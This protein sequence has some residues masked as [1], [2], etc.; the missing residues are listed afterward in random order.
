MSRLFERRGGCA[1]HR[2][3]AKSGA[4]I[5]LQHKLLLDNDLTFRSLRHF[6]ASFQTVVFRVTE[7]A[8]R[9]PLGEFGGGGGV[10]CLKYHSQHDLRTAK[11]TAKLA[12]DLAVWRWN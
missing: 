7:S 4:E 2:G 1:T 3:V 5:A 9:S 8:S 11:S 6:L 12:V 10:F